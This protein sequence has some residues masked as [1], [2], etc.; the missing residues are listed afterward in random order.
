MLASLPCWSWSNDPI[1]SNLA[2]L[3]ARTFGF[4]RELLV[5]RAATSLHAAANEGLKIEK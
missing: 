4:E 2:F 1:G 3:V 5:A